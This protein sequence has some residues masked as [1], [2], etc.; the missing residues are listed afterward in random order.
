MSLRYE[1]H[2]ALK[3]TRELLRDLF[4]VENYPKTKKEM[5]KRASLCLKHYPFLNENGMPMFSRDEFTADDG[6]PTR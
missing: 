2:R 5:R 6:G 3:I 4:T 1:Q